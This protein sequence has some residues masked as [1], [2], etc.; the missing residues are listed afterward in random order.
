[1]DGINEDYIHPESKFINDQHTIMAAERGDNIIAQVL[2][3]N[4]ESVLHRINYF[5]NH[6]YSVHL[7][8]TELDKNKSLGRAISRYFGTGRYHDI[9][10]LMISDPQKIEDT[11]NS[12]KGESI[13]DG[14][15]KWN[16]DTPRGELPILLE[17]SDGTEAAF[18][19]GNEADLRRDAPVQSPLQ[20]GNPG[21]GDNAPEGVYNGGG[22]GGLT[23]PSTPTPVNTDGS[24]PP[25]VRGG[26]SDFNIG[27]HQWGREGAQQTNFLSQETKDWI[28]AHNEYIKDTNKDQLD[29]SIAWVESHIAQNDPEGFYGAM[30]EVEDEGFN[31]M[32]AD[33]QV[34][35]LTL[36]SIA[37]KNNDHDAEVRLSDIYNQAGTDPARALQARKIFR[38]MTPAGRELALKREAQK[39]EDEYNLRRKNKLKLNISKETLD[40][41]ANAKSEKEFTEAR[42][43]LEEELAAQIPSDWRLK[44]RTWRMAAM[45]ANPRTHIRNLEGNFSFIIPM[46]IKNT[47][48][49]GLERMAKVPVGE[50]TK[51]PSKSKEAISFAQKD[52]VEMKDV[53][54]GTNKYFEVNAV[55][56]NRK[57][58]GQGKSLLSRTVGRAVQW[59]ADKNG[60]L[61]EK[62]DWISLNR[63]Y[64]NAMASFMT[65]NGYTEK[66]M[67]GDT[68]KK[69]RE[70]AVRE[71]QKATYRD[72]NKLAKWFSDESNKPAALQFLVNAVIPFT[73]TPMNI[74][75]R[76]VEY[77][78]FGLAY[79][80]STA[81]RKLEAYK[82]W[83]E[84][85]FKGK[86]PKN[87]KS[88]GEV[89]DSIASGLTGTMLA[90]LGAFLSSLGAL[91][92]KPTEA[93]KRKGSQDYSIELFGKSFGIG[94]LLPT[95]LPILFGGSVYEEI[96]KLKEGGADLGSVLQSFSNMIQPSLETTMWMSL[97]SLLDTGRYITDNESAASVLGQKIL[98]NYASSFLP[99]VVGATAKV[100]DPTKRKAYVQP[101]DSM[102]VWTVLRE[103][104]ENKL[105]FLSRGNVP[106]LDKWGEEQTESRFMAFLHNFIL[107]DRVQDLTDSELD[108]KLAEITKRTGIDVEPN[109]T[110]QKT[111]TVNSESVPLTDKQWYQY[112]SSRGKTSKAVLQELIERPEFIVL[113][114]EVQASLIKNV[115][116]YAKAKAALELFPDKNITDGWTKGALTADNVV[117]YIFEKAEESAKKASNDEHRDSLY[118]AIYSGNYEAASVDVDALRTAGVSDSSIK[119][120]ITNHF[121]PIYKTAYEGGD[122]DEMG[123][124]RAMLRSLGLGYENYDFN[125]WL[126]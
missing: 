24:T 126:K 80:L 19:G 113:T 98:A 125:K 124:I 91:K 73:K 75:R 38:L 30:R 29:R 121:K 33:G 26:V 51:S 11:F 71:A 97:S 118:K 62:E 74:V 45:L 61:L 12:V 66:D 123:E 6:G 79:S 21:S 110:N 108:D 117:D 55:E 95:A 17:A 1:M 3:E 8:M 76:G 87:A 81:K 114:P 106:Y 34:R 99:S 86:Q 22:S 68:L 16:T 89:F 57:A 2:G 112:S 31:S 65:A 59:A 96:S 23:P 53:L 82:A 50:R 56:A 60:A 100:V 28:L 37:Q 48:G 70:Y 58:F 101:G 67:K 104:T 111:L 18:L 35:I 64:V 90:G 93:E 84:S 107:P 122:Y 10:H 105:P 15:T 39:V 77:S 92:V 9:R 52:A 7:H 13:I 49:A 4:E 14:Y 32:T 72:A 78:P 63:H 25:P 40:A 69:A 47:I 85:G 115:Y 119:S 20:T 120:S 83:E 44:A 102:S 42:R 41:A 116:S 46:S 88:P 109:A 43:R 54:Q 36:L 27:Q 5:R 94:N 103:Q